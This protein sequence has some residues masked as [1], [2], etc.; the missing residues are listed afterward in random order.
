MFHFQVTILLSMIGSFFVANA[1]NA[2]FADILSNVCTN[3]KINSDIFE[4]INTPILDEHGLTATITLRPANRD[5]RIAVITITD[6]Q[7]RPHAEIRLSKKCLVVQGRQ[8]IWDENG[9]RTAIHDLGPDLET[10]IQKTMMNPEQKF[11]A[12][13]NDAMP[14][15]PRIA[16]VD[17]GVNYTLPAF[18]PNV[19]VD[20]SDRLIGYDFW[21]D[22][23]WPYD[24]DPRRNPFYPT[25]HGSTVFSVLL[26][27]AP[28]STIS[29]YRFPAL[30]MCRFKELLAHI[31][32]TDVRLV[33]LS[34]GSNDPDDWH[35]FAIAAKA[36]PHVLFVVSAGNNGRNIDEQPVYPA[37]IALANMVVVSSS[38]NFGMLGAGSNYGPQTVDILVP[39]EQVSI[40]DHRGAKAKT[41]GTSYAAPRVTALLARYLAKKPDATPVQMIDLLRK[42][43]IPTSEPLSKFGWIPDPSDDFGF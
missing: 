11:T 3:L 27:E 8:L 9:N 33:N 15:N 28:E 1:A 26:D 5:W 23:P 12:K 7:A 17:T 13:P 42:R 40:L 35:C 32:N 18:W 22:D 4:I 25:H 36:M 39:A 29:L 6:E 37:S 10:I 20:K 19:A 14:G 24:S 2:S 21:D 16:L 31:A 30:E 34:M 38:D 43:A 41:G